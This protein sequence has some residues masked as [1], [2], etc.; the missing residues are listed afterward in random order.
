MIRILYAG[1][2]KWQFAYQANYRKHD[3]CSYCG[4][5]RIN[6]LKSV[7][8]SLRLQHKCLYGTSAASSS[9]VA[10]SHALKRC[11]KK[12]RQKYDPH[13][14]EIN[15]LVLK[16]VARISIEHGTCFRFDT[17]SGI[18]NYADF[19]P[20]DIHWPVNLCN[21]T[22]IFKILAQV[23][24]SWFNQ[25]LSLKYCRRLFCCPGY[26]EGVQYTYS[27]STDWILGVFMHPRGL[28]W[29]N[30]GELLWESC[31]H[32]HPILPQDA[33]PSVQ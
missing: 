11:L 17:K 31:R 25:K 6:R 19:V 7:F 32:G 27:W 24:Q 12:R 18:S 10:L 21:Q 5:C 33:I 30:L 2:T 26:D 29:P 8:P 4:T 14:R 23:F 20:R 13:K 1:Q 15:F 9:N 28:A 22:K 16:R 3:K